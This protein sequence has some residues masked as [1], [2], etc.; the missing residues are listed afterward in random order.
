MTSVSFGV[1]P[2][3]VTPRPGAAEADIARISAKIPSA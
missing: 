2:K 1:K 3:R